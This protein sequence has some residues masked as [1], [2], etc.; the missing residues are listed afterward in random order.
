MTTVNPTY[1]L[2]RSPAQP[3]SVRCFAVPMGRDI[4]NSQVTAEQTAAIIEREVGRLLQ[5]ALAAAQIPGVTPASGSVYAQAAPSAAANAAAVRSELATELARIDATVSSRLATAGYTA[6]SNAAIAA[7][8]AKTDN[9][10][11][12]PASQ[13]D[14]PSAAENA[15]AAGQRIIEGGL[16][17]DAIQRI[18]LAA[19]VGKTAG[20]GGAS[21]TYFAQDGTTPRV[22]A[23]FD[24]DNN[25]TSVTLDGDA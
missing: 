7:I 13:D 20:I 21:E 4:T 18:Q 6:P 9:L 25:R 15:D 24:Q 3:V 10:P 22:V 5:L 19:L 23:G 2:I 8:R 14:I 17:A 11:A 16:T 12:V 1:L